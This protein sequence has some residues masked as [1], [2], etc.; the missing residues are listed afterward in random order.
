MYP[1]FSSSLCVKLFNLVIAPLGSG[2]GIPLL[3]APDDLDPVLPL[4]KVLNPK[5]FL[6]NG[7]Q[8]IILA[9]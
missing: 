8:H 6:S 4:K 1:T 3:A 9:T 5:I 7:H 2:V